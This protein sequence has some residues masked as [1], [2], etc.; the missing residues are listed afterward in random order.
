MGIAM[1][2]EKKKEKKKKRGFWNC[3][4]KASRTNERNRGKKRR[5]LGVWVGWSFHLRA[6]SPFIYII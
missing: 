5:W 4:M 6:K 1:S 3:L 2:R